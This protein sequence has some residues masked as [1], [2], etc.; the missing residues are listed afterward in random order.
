MDTIGLKI[1]ATLTSLTLRIA[2]ATSCGP[3]SVVHGFS[4]Q[5]AFHTVRC[6][7]PPRVVCFA[8]ARLEDRLHQRDELKGMSKSTLSGSVTYES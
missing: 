4:F 1:F 7:F 5:E 2:A 3:V 8:N 6:Q